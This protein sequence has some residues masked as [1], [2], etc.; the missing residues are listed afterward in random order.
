MGWLIAL[1]VVIAISFLPL[2]VSFRYDAGGFRFGFLAG[3]IRI[4]VAGG[5]EKKEKKKK[6]KKK[7]K[8]GKD[9]S[10]P[11]GQ[12]KTKKKGGSLSDFI[13]FIELVLDFLQAFRRKLRIRRLDIKLIMASDDP[14][15]LAVNYGRAWAAVG[16]LMPRL[17]KIFVIKR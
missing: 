10:A 2:G 15:D 3:L 5:K 14:C 7:S 1:G 12:G 6:T 16:N 17:E 4:P 11:S 8:S 9:P 13:P